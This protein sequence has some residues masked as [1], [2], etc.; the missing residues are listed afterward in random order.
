[1]CML[2]VLAFFVVPYLLKKIVSSAQNLL[3]KY[4]LWSFKYTINAS[5]VVLVLWLLLLL[6]VVFL[7]PVE[8]VF[9]IVILV[10]YVVVVV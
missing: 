3:E 8:V 7:L 5:V 10:R 2:C 6:P 1:M 4:R 9:E